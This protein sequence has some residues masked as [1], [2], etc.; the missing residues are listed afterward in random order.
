M[1]SPEAG[2]EYLRP[3]E[4]AKLLHVSPKTIDRWAADGRI[5]CIV[6]LGGHR[7][8]RIDDVLAV[9]EQMARPVES[10]TK[11]ER[12]ANPAKAVKPVSSGK[13]AKAAK[14]TKAAKGKGTSAKRRSGGERRPRD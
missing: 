1:S 2:G 4:A 14:A 7:R 12:D 3:S 5:P 8:F 13:A 6:T 9:A 11:G 10:L